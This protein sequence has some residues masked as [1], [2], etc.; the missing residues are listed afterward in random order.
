M[1]NGAP[2]DASRV[3]KPGLVDLSGPLVYHLA[4]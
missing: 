2:P 4:A 1:L 3:W